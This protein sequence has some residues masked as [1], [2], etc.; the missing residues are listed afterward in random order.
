MKTAAFLAALL[1][2]GAAAF[3][4]DETIGVRLREWYVTLNGRIESDTDL[5]DGT[6]IDLDSTLGLDDR[7]TAHEVQAYLGIPVL[8]NF[9]AGWWFVEFEGT[10]VLSRTISFADVSF[11]AATTVET[12]FNLDV[13]YLSYEFSLPTLPLAPDTWLDWG[14]LAGVRV[15]RAEGEIASTGL[16]ASDNGAVGLPVL[17]LHGVLQVTP[18]VR[19]EAELMGLAFSSGTRSG[20]YVEAY[21]EVVGQIGPFFAGVGY[22]WVDLRL[23]DEGGDADF[24]I[25]LAL[26]GAYLTA[27]LRF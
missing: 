11:T 27:G 24:S 13:W 14:V 10:E 26:D 19:A 22:K 7:E 17:G 20:R 12:V 8:G 6:N 16:E 23:K 2:P 5:L 1:G 4:Q 9:Y 21:M 18:F 3:A 25:D 15:I